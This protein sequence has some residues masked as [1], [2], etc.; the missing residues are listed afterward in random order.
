[1]LRV[2]GT[3]KGG[4]KGLQ[5]GF[6]GGFKGASKF[7]GCRG[8][9]GSFFFNFGAGFHGIPCVWGVH[10]LRATEL[11]EVSWGPSSVHSRYRLGV[12]ILGQYSV[13]RAFSRV[14]FA[15]DRLFQSC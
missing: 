3:L 7:W 11:H 8:F 10:I 6:K 2:K 15:G 9:Y 13:C 4:F 14:A 1:M 12:Y 5:G